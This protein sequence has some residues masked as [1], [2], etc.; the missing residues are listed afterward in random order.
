MTVRRLGTFW[1][2]SKWTFFGARLEHKNVAAADTVEE[3]RAVR[4]SFIFSLLDFSNV[5]SSNFVTLAVSSSIEVIAREDDG[6]VGSHGGQG[7]QTTIVGVAEK[8]G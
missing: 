1:S 5:S 7:G 3:I 8:E 4:N 6:G 2:L